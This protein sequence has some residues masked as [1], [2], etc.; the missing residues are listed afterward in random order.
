MYLANDRRDKA[1]ALI[2]EAFEKRRPGIVWLAVAPDWDA[3][4]S[5]PRFHELIEM[6]GLPTRAKAP[7]PP[8]R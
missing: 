5:E 3:L 8:L 2:E 6:V 4:E 7:V 1:M